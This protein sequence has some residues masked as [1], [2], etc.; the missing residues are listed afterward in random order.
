MKRTKEIDKRLSQLED[1]KIWLM[2]ESEKRRAKFDEKS[3]RAQNSD[4][5]QEEESEIS[6]LEDEANTAENLL[7]S[8]QSLFNEE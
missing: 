2:E 1:I 4:K 7:E 6:V 8:L 5:G 3:E